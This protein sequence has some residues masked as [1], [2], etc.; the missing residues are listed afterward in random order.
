MK[1]RNVKIM[2]CENH[3]IGC[4]IVKSRE[5]WVKIIPPPTC[6]RRLSENISNFPPPTCEWKK[7]PL[8]PLWEYPI[9]AERQRCEVRRWEHP[10]KYPLNLYLGP[11][12]PLGLAGWG[13][14]WPSDDDDDEKEHVFGSIG[15]QPLIDIIISCLIESGRGH[16]R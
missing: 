12:I 8:P 4:K 15:K 7:W 13:K 11:T 1:T 10:K 3:Y 16:L 14:L 5:D 2:T 9:R 6:E